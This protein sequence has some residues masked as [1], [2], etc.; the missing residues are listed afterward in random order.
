[1][2]ESLFLQE[3]AEHQR[4]RKLLMPAFHDKALVNYV[5]T[6]T[7]ITDR[8]LTKWA[9]IGKLTWFPELKNLTFEIASV[10]INWQRA[11]CRNY[12]VESVIYRTD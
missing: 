9:E 10:L 11:R 3:G 1:L 6:M 4:N 2:G 7:E 5:S 8:Y 12:R